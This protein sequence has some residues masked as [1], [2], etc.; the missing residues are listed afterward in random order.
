MTLLY[1]TLLQRKYN[2]YIFY[3]KR[4]S[5]FTVLD[6][7]PYWFTSSNGNSWIKVL[8]INIKG[9]I[10][11]TWQCLSYNP[12]IKGHGM[13]RIFT[14]SVIQEILRTSLWYIFAEYQEGINLVYILCNIRSR[15]HF[16]SK[17]Y[18]IR[19]CFYW[20]RKLMIINCL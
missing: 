6:K 11:C 12:P 19:I 20:L 2:F 4:S 16:V 15:R 1:M 14:I 18:A 13:L 8:D 17:M 9:W 10:N 5:C 7:I 3:A